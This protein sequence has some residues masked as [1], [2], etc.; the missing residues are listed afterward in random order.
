MHELVLLIRICLPCRELSGVGMLA[1]FRLDARR[2][3][4]SPARLEHVR[5]AVDLTFG[6]RG[7][8]VLTLV[9]PSGTRSRLL[10]RR[11][12]DKRRGSFNAWPF[13]STHFWGEQPEGSWTLLVENASPHRN[14]GKS[15]LLPTLGRQRKD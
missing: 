6:S 15:P 2:C 8:L 10:G 13:M 1:S 7:A 9:S 5:A 4:G 12:R 3:G 14:F 11:P